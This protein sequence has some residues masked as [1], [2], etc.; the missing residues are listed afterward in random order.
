MSS[1]T[2]TAGMS[3]RHAVLGLLSIE[4]S[5]GYELTRR[6]DSS[7]AHAWHASHSQIYPLLSRLEREGLVE[8]VSEGARRS[9]TWA[10]TDAGRA[11]LR[12]WLVATAPDRGQ[13]NESGVRWFLQELLAPADRRA[14]LEQELA[15]VRAANDQLRERAE[16]KHAEEGDRPRGFTASLDLGL[17][18]QA[19]MIAWLEEQLEALDEAG[20]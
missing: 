14:V 16:R 20:A 13:R 15:Y 11:E 12:H 10:V 8:V 5:T 2:Y 7:L 6:F 1:P 19:V 3:L 18:I 9:R 17:R 4:P